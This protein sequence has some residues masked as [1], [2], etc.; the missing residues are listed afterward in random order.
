M[1]ADS[2]PMAVATAG[3]VGVGPLLY[4]FT[5]GLVAAVNPCGFPLLPAYL[6]MFAGEGTGTGHIKQTVR[7][8]VAGASVSAGFVMVFGVVGVAAESGAGVVISWAPWAMVVLGAA[9]AA[10][11]VLVLAGREPHVR[12]RAPGFRVP[13]RDQVGSARRAAAMV[14]F[15]AAY[16]VASLS[17]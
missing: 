11:G 3:Q 12:L 13:Q 8:L 1:F 14:G 9:L 10:F 15:G 4:A 17:C 2:M 5:L 7:G 16:A 6:A